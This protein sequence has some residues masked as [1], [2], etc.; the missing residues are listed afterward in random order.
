MVRLLAILVRLVVI[1]FS[2]F[3]VHRFGIPTPPVASEEEVKKKARL[4]RFA[5][6]A[7]MDPLEDDKRKAR[8]LRCG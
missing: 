1:V 2:L 8:A 7:K 5:H 3:M 6:A 4:A